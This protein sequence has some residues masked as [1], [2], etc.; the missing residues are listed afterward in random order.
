MRKL[1][2][3]P[4]ISSMSIAAGRLTLAGDAAR[5]LRLAACTRRPKSRAVGHDF[6]ELLRLALSADF[7]VRRR[8]A[9]DCCRISSRRSSGL[10][11]TLPPMRRRCAGILGWRT[12]HFCRA[13][14]SG[15][16][17]ER[18]RRTKRLPHRGADRRHAWTAGTASGA[19]RR[20]SRAPHL[21]AAIRFAVS[22]GADRGPPLADDRGRG[23]GGDRLGRA[24]MAR[25]RQRELASLR[26]LDADHQ[27][28]RAERR[29]RR[30]RAGCKACSGWCAPLA[31]AKHWRGSVQA[32]GSIAVAAVGSF[33]C[34]AS[35]APFELKAAALAAGTLVATP[36]LYMYDWSCSPSPSLFCCGL[37]SSADLPP[38]KSPDLASPAR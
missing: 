23:R 21:Q 9:G 19:R 18:D 16:A 5:R 15:R 4:T 13:R 38:A 25:F 10:L 6:R 14:I 33:G 37:R 30:F 34:G 26:A 7:S 8:R 22:A 17:L 36:Y 1:G 28:R 27:P 20:L 3:S 2:R 11:A 12:G 24:L 29:P 35:R 31:A 32:I